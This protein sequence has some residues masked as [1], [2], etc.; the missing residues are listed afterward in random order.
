MVHDFLLL[1][2]L[3]D[4]KAANI[5]RRLAIDALKTALT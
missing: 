4:T 1:D 3:R 5:A 2:S